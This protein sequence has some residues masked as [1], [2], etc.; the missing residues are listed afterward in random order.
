VTVHR[1]SMF[2]VK[3]RNGA[4]ISVNVNATREQPRWI[5]HW[6]VQ[7]SRFP[8]IRDSYTRRLGVLHNRSGWLSWQ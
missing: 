7:N 3:K 6:K 5:L 8:A 4:S 1:T 2:S